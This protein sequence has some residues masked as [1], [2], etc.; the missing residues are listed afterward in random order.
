[1]SGEVKSITR[2]LAVDDEPINIEVIHRILT[3]D[4]QVFMA[5]SGPQALQIAQRQRPDVILLDVNM[6]G[7]D[8]FVTCERLLATPGLARTPV[9]FVTAQADPVRES[10]GLAAGGVDFIS[11]PVQPSVLR[12][13]VHRHAEMH[14]KA[15]HLRVV[16]M[17]GDQPGVFSKAFLE[18]RMSLACGLARKN[19]ACVALLI[20]RLVRLNDDAP[21]VDRYYA[22][23]AALLRTQLRC[24]GDVLADWGDDALACLKMDFRGDTA[25]ALAA[26]CALA[27]ERFVMEQGCHLRLQIGIG[28]AAA[29]SAVP[30]QLL[31]SAMRDLGSGRRLGAVSA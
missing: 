6:P 14:R 17:Q 29:G 18:A 19:N 4:Y 12:D 7:V 1:M 20:F 28:L 23:V 10:A 22:D 5:T 30:D 11:K 2:V 31:L 24:V 3:P 8:G 26:R 13:C 9:I 21:P 16:A 27:F 15:E 25:E